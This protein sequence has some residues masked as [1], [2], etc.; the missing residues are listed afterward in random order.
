VK[1]RCVVT[2]FVRE[3]VYLFQI[4]LSVSL[5]SVEVILKLSDCRMAS[6]GRYRSFP[7]D[8]LFIASEK[9]LNLRSSI[10][11]L[12]TKVATQYNWQN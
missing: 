12:A 4:F 7:H 8:A 6:C 9:S 3:F 10:N 2:K 5:F 1:T 11:R